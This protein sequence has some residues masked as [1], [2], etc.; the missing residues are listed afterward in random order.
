[1]HWQVTPSMRP[2]YSTP[3]GCEKMAATLSVACAT[4][5]RWMRRLATVEL[6]RAGRFTK[7]SKRTSKAMAIN[8]IL[9][10]RRVE[11]AR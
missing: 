7:A 1:V 9:I 5:L 6:L 10:E 8:G 11:V 4:K 2:V 3:L